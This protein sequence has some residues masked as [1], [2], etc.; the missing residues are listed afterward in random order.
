MKI[1]PMLV[2][3]LEKKS[4]N[5][6]ILVSLYANYYRKVISNEIKLASITAKDHVLNVG[7]GAI[8]FTA[9]LTAKMTG[10]RV[11]AIDCDKAAVKIARLC[12]AKQQLDHLI[13]VMH[14]NGID[15]IPFNFDVAIVALQAKPKK[16]IMENLL[17]RSSAQNRLV[18]RRPRSKIAHLYDMLPS[19]PHFSN[20][21]NQEMATFDRSVLY[22]STAILQV[23]RPDQK[24]S[25]P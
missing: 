2:A 9:I 12:V 23:C 4:A 13:T 11:W 10:A 7:C 21:I 5:N 6:K 20:S 19:R 1:I 15:A 3:S 16:E 25:D 14:L 18:F 24:F 8:P 22:V 17:E